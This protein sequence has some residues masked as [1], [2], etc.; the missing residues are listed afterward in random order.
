MAAV[1]LQNEGTCTAPHAQQT[2]QFYWRSARGRRS[3][4]SVTV[5]RWTKADMLGSRARKDGMQSADSHLRLIREEAHMCRGGG[6]SQLQALLVEQQAKGLH[7]THTP[8][9]E[10]VEFSIEQKL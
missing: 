1:D 6:D 4:T 3:A 5:K 7:T 10:P 2:N 9:H 8:K